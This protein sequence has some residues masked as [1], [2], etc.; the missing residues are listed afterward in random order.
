MNKRRGRAIS[1]RLSSVRK[2]ARSTAPSTVWGRKSANLSKRKTRVATNSARHRSGEGALSETQRTMAKLVQAHREG[3]SFIGDPGG[4]GNGWRRVAVPIQTRYGQLWEQLRR[5]APTGHRALV[6]D[7]H[8]FA[9]D[10]DDTNRMTRCAR[11]LD[12]RKY[13]AVQYRGEEYF[14]TESKL[15]QFA[16]RTVRGDTSKLSV[17]GYSFGGLIA[18]ALL[19]HNERLNQVVKNG[20]FYLFE[21]TATQFTD[22]MVGSAKIQIFLNVHD[23]MANAENLLPLLRKERTQNYWISRYKPDEDDDSECHE[24]AQWCE[25]KRALLSRADDGTELEE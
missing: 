12:P 14:Q 8:Y 5:G 15:L 1:D 2:K 20:R 17:V 9:D 3:S 7:G 10:P 21:P 25:D 16:L 23:W 13:G 19:E 22:T 6:F 4:F 18:M 24:L 11:A